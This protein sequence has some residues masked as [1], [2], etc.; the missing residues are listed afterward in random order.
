MQ[1]ITELKIQQKQ[2]LNL[3]SFIQAEENFNFLINSHKLLVNE[4]ID[5]YHH[6]LKT[7]CLNKK[8]IEANETQNYDL[9]DK[10]ISNF[11]E[12]LSDNGDFLVSFSQYETFF[13][14][15]EYYNI[16]AL[17]VF[18]LSKYGIKKLHDQLS[19]RNL[20]FLSIIAEKAQLI[21][22]SY[23]GNTS[24]LQPDLPT[25]EYYEE[26]KLRLDKF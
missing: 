18:K 19:Q 6:I 4:S 3:Q 22:D 2:S 26:I 23:S 20:I 13:E 16:S 7:K 8:M 24:S 10:K 17:P 5:F 25:Y 1:K 15:G 14:N 9:I 21:L 11:I 12:Q